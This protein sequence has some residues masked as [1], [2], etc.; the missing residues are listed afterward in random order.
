MS[1]HLYYNF[2]LSFS[3]LLQSHLA[4]NITPEHVSSLVKFS[5][6]MDNLELS[7][8]SASIISKLKMNGNM[9]VFCLFSSS[10]ILSVTGTMTDSVFLA[11]IHI[12]SNA[13]LCL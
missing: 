1:P 7:Y 8:R 11:I 2:S 4:T 3:D 12:F 10:L 9:H 5:A 6:Q 13:I